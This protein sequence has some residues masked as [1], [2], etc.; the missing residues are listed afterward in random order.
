MVY[1]E[2]CSG[3]H[4]QKRVIFGNRQI[5]GK[6][7]GEGDTSTSQYACHVGMY[8]L[9]SGY[10]YITVCGSDLQWRE[11]GVQQSLEEEGEVVWECLESSPGRYSLS[12]FLIDHHHHWHQVGLRTLVEGDRANANAKTKVFSVF[13]VWTALSTNKYYTDINSD[14]WLDLL[15]SPINYLTYRIN[16]VWNSHDLGW[17]WARGNSPDI[18]CTPR[19]LSV[20]RHSFKRERQR[21]RHWNFKEPSL[22]WSF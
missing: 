5:L 1:L 7:N 2:S 22:T 16:F 21:L 12:P 8:N 13:L 9:S 14:D 20:G 18:D 17:S 15:R 6:S 10:H 11:T 4:T 3:G 19:P